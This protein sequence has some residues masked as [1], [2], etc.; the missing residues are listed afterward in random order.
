MAET[1]NTNLDETRSH[2][3]PAHLERNLRQWSGLV[4]MLFVTSHLLNHAAG[5]FGISMMSAAQEMRVVVWRSW[6]GTL[7]LYGSLLVHVML[8]M[9]RVLL[10]RTWR[11][12]ASEALQIGLGFLIPL[13]LVGHVSG[14]RLASSVAGIDD[15][16]VNVLRYLWPEHALWQIL[17]LSVVWLHGC[18]G[19]HY[20]FHVQRWFI[21]LRPALTAIAYLVP[22]LAIAGFIGEG[23]EAAGL[24]LAPEQWTPKQEAAILQARMLAKN[25]VYI[26]MA[27]CVIVLVILQVRRRL[28][29]KITVRYTGHGDVRGQRGLTLLELSRENRIP[30]PSTCGGKGRCS[31]CRVLVLNGV[32]KLPPPTPLEQRILDRIQAPHGVRLACQIRPERDLRVKIL[33]ADQ[34][35]TEGQL[36]LDF[37]TA[38]TTD[39]AVLFADIRAFS[40]LGRTQL[41]GDVIVMLDHVLK[42]LV[43]ATV[44]HSGKVV[45]LQTDGMMAIFEMK[46]D[47]RAGARAALDCADAMLAAADSANRHFAKVLPI[48]LRVG[49]GIHVG[50][51]VIARQQKPFTSDPAH[52]APGAQGLVVIGETVTIASRLEEATKELSADCVISRDTYDAARITRPN[53]ALSQISVKN[54]DRQV[55]A[56]PVNRAR[57]VDAEP[58]PETQSV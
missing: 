13:L 24:A 35:N 26:F 37:A 29:R 46:S 55:A 1:K 32:D 9:R 17:A 3:C 48:P 7:L 33:M 5:I 57:P 14:T 27:A 31:S 36:G 51:A 15:S 40:Q 8:T 53:V 58:V 45:Q 16:Y 34:L 39:V 54:S 28:D 30:H 44:A 52:L 19:I 50:P 12:P 56:Y 11:M 20:A 49:I 2:W 21:M 23:R 47:A 43:Q 4:L 41:P 42:D 6:P 18:L 22:A 38:H 10:R 25:A